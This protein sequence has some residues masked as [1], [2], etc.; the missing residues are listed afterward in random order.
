MSFLKWIKNKFSKS[1]D[2]PVFWYYKY[3]AQK[4]D[5]WLFE[6]YKDEE[7]LNTSIIYERYSWFCTN[8]KIAQS[9]VVEI[10]K[11]IPPLGGKMSTKLDNEVVRNWWRE[12]VGHAKSVGLKDYQG[13]HIPMFNPVMNRYRVMCS[14]I[15]TELAYNYLCTLGVDVSVNGEI[16][17][18]KEEADQYIDFQKMME[19]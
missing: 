11:T 3:G 10:L 13:I 16:F 7:Q 4:E 19:E 14:Q 9:R 17:L 1:L 8:Y 12:V 5:F 6:K 2:N 18:T 15:R